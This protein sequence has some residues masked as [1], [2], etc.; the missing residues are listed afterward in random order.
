MEKY[1]AFID[2]LGFKAKLKNFS[3]TEAESY[4]TEFSSMLY[5]EWQRLNCHTNPNIQGFI[6][7]DSIVIHTID[8]SRDC[9]ALL[10]EILI[11][12]CKKAFKD[13]S[14]LLRGAVAKGEF[15]QLDAGSFNNL[16]KGLIVGQ[17]YVE[18]YTLEN[19]TKTSAINLTKDVFDDIRNYFDQSVYDPIAAKT[20]D[21]ENYLLRWADIDFILDKDNLHG[22]VGL[23]KEAEW[24]PHYYNTLY[25]FLYRN[26]N[27]KKADQLFTNVVE[28]LSAGKY[29][30]N[31][32]QIDKFIENTFAPDVQ[33]EYKQM[34]MRFLRQSFF[35][36]AAN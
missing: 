28:L 23:A 22:F 34:F 14:I 36:S 35:Q 6:V 2:I 25:L 4:I 33:H 12:L 19:A 16:Q 26:R 32:R 29:S 11:S 1:V 24:P 31:W 15:R 10:L 20:S 5:D 8:T 7:S 17:A 21:R 3:Q 18:A 30:E 9:L 27:E 13:Q